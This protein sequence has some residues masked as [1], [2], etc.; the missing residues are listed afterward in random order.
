MGVQVPHRA[1]EI[2]GRERVPTFFAHSEMSLSNQPL[3]QV[4][5]EA[6]RAAGAI[7]RAGWGEIHNVEMKGAINPVTEIDHAA[8]RSILER[9]RAATPTFSILAEES[10]AFENDAEWRWVIDPL[11]GTVNYAHHFPYFAVSLGLVHQGQSE[12]G[13]VYDPILDQLFSAERSGGAY[14]N[15][16]PIHCSRTAT[17]AQCIVATGFPY[18]VWQSGK[19]TLELARVVRRAQTVRVNGCAALDMAYVACGRFDAY[20]DAGLYPWDAAAA[21]LLVTEAGG[22]FTEYG[23]EPAQLDTRMIIASNGRIHSELAEIVLD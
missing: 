17:L 6:V 5:A 20:Y 21:R 4:A 1:L 18:D 22:T 3:L 16:Q 19:N 8:E 7:I 14:L 11:D 9:L 12:I 15:G 23:G 2:L 13:V 10:G